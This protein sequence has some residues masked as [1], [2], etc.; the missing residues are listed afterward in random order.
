MIRRPSNLPLTW[1]PLFNVAYADPAMRKRPTRE[2]SNINPVK[3][4]IEGK[5]F[6]EAEIERVQTQ[7][8]SRDA[9]LDQLFGT[10]D[11]FSLPI[12][13]LLDHRVRMPQAI[14]A[15]AIANGAP[16][17]EKLLSRMSS[18]S[19]NPQAS[20]LVMAAISRSVEADAELLADAATRYPDF[21]RLSLS[22]RLGDFGRAI[23]VPDE[24]VFRSIVGM[25][26][27]YYGIL[28][29]Q[30]IGLR[31]AAI[32]EYR[33]GLQGDSDTS[34]IGQHSKDLRQLY[35]GLKF[36]WEEIKRAKPSA[37]RRPSIVSYMK[38]AGEKALA[39]IKKRDPKLT[40]RDI[41]DMAVR[42]FRRSSK[43]MLSEAEYLDKLYRILTSAQKAKRGQPLRKEVTTVAAGV[44]A[45]NQVAFAT[46]RL[47][48]LVDEV[49]EAVKYPAKGIRTPWQDC[50]GPIPAINCKKMGGLFLV[51]MRLIRKEP[52]L[53][54]LFTKSGSHADL[55]GQIEQ[56]KPIAIGYDTFRLVRDIHLDWFSRKASAAHG[57]L[58]GSAKWDILPC[59]RF[60]SSLSDTPWKFER[61]PTSLELMQ[62]SVVA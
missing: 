47:M 3:V 48:S 56:S 6:P 31:Q 41:T 54:P 22:G 58:V 45:G 20:G 29:L 57:K 42:L 18:M 35:E 26:A 46:M 15:S 44:E 53:G 51:V 37:G 38:S 8:L 19:A 13:H 60:S 32:E 55:I 62:R 39:D 24:A 12:G 27:I 59:Y 36:V 5:I 52:S 23:N 34:T 10:V 1:K 4:V 50:F 21:V 11:P 2:L 14:A 61:L 9:F 28:E 30:I 25:M 16:E 40:D 49:N 7:G 17:I 43:K 33:I